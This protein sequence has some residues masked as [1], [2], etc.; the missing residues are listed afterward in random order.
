MISDNK[1][2]KLKISWKIRAAGYMEGIDFSQRSN[3]A[4]NTSKELTLN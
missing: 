2:G 4:I 3:V 1:L